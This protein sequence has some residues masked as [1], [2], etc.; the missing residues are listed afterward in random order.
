MSCPRVLL[1]EDDTALAPILVAISSDEQI[2]VSCCTSLE[3]IR[4]A[5]RDE[6]SAIVV[7]DS[8]AEGSR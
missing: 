4:V 3:E 6:L 1:C 8:C 7:F 5:L 2:D